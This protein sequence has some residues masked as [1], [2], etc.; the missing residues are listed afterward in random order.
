VHK[1]RYGYLPEGCSEACTLDRHVPYEEREPGCNHDP[2]AW[3][4]VE[5]DDVQG[6][7]VRQ[8]E[9]GARVLTEE[10]VRQLMVLRDQYRGE[11]PPQ[12]PHSSYQDES[13]SVGA[14]DRDLAYFDKIMEVLTQ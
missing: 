9:C 2:Q 4:I 10:Q 6:V 5:V 14:T 1:L 7:E 13:E 3:R 8:C 12:N 11:P